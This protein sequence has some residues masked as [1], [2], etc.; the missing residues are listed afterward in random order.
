MNPDGTVKEKNSSKYQSPQQQNVKFSEICFMAPERITGN[1][2][3]D[4]IELSKRTDIWS[5]GVIV[6]VLFSGQLPFKGETCQQLYEAIK[7]SEFMFPGP[8]WEHIP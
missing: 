5:I 6:Y 4:E 3:F 8:E 7:R 1:L 2:K